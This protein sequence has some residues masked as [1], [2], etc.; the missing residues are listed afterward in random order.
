LQID[1]RKMDDLPTILATITTE[2]PSTEDA[3]RIYDLNVQLSDLGASLSLNDPETM[4]AQPPQINHYTDNPS[5]PSAG[6]PFLVQEQ[7]D[8]SSPPGKHSPPV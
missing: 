3:H 2:L 5:D 7:H 1:L 8:P 6:T 4:Y